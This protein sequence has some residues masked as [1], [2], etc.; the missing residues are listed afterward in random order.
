MMNN[1]DDQNEV[2]LLRRD[3]ELIRERYLRLADLHGKL[4]TQNSLL[5]ERVLNLIENSTKD[6]EK[7]EQSLS[8]A[9]Q[10]IDYLQETVQQLQIDK[11][12]YKA[13]CNLAVRLLHRYPDD[14]L[15]THSDQLEERLKTVRKITD[16]LHRHGFSSFRVRL[17]HNDQ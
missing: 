2:Q 3:L 9:Q 14:F 4:Q 1:I 16:F 13:D 11:Q 12:K 7:L 17:S 5:E 8:D 10:Q 15:A 6:K